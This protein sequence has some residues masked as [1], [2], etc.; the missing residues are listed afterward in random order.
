MI[1]LLAIATLQIPSGAAV[2]QISPSAQIGL[3]SSAPEPLPNA[4]F[5]AELLRERLEEELKDPDSAVIK[6]TGVPRWM[7]VKKYI[8]SK[9]AT[10]WTMCF[11]VNGRNS[12]G[13]YA[14]NS[15]YIVVVAGG[16][17]LYSESAEQATGY[18]LLKYIN[19][20]CRRA[21]G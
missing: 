16:R 4:E 17:L 1:A 9:P 12:F 13:G 3:D 10:G 14:G 11:R 15:R 18:N 7:S 2:T 5:V 21:S 20:V 6:P 8:Y 19:P